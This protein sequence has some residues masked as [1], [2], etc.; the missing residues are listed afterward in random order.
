MSDQPKQWQCPDC[1]GWVDAAWWRH[2]HVAPTPQ[3]RA[4]MTVARELH[5]DVPSI[6]DSVTVHH[7]QRT[8]DE[9]TREKPL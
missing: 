5:G 2:V 1:K 4:E 8:G 9:P 7:Y 6:L 3:T